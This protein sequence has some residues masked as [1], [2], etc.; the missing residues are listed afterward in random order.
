MR[1]NIQLPCA[2]GPVTISIP[3]SAAPTGGTGLGVS[4]HRSWRAEGVGAEGGGTLPPR[5]HLC[6]QKAPSLLHSLSF[7]HLEDQIN[8]CTANFYTFLDHCPQPLDTVDLERSPH[9]D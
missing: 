9:K 8:S 1:Q 2:Q 7:K 6:M 4:V 3:D 5:K